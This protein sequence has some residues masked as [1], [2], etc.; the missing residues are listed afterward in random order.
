MKKLMLIMAVAMFTVA[1]HA[2]VKIGYVDMQKAVQSTKAG[3]KA[4]KELE[5]EFEKRKKTLQT[6]ESDL[7]K[8]GEDL[9]KK[10]MV[11]S[12]DVRAKKQKEFQ[13][14]MMEFQQNVQKNQ[15]EIQEQEKKLTEPILKK[16]SEVIGDIAKKDN[17]TV[18]LEKRENAVLW[19][20][21]DLDIT[22]QVVKAFETKK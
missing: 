7:K 6:K 18:I 22:D 10:A 16:L 5:T 14:S 20:Q 4:K 3:Q 11:L 2:E 9:E 19:A 13:E 1:A 12:D 8:M 21:K 17:Y 15:Q